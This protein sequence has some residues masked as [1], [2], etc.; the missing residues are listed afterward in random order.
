MTPD[1]SGTLEHRL[2]IDDVRHHAE[3]VKDIAL[4]EVK[5]FRDEQSTRAAIVGLV[6]VVGVV[7][8]AYYLGTRASRS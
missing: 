6:V 7:S 2:T 1:T 4:S 3:E 8:L 5:R